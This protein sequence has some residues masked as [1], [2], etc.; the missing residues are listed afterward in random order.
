[1]GTHRPATHS[2]RI[3]RAIASGEAARSALIASWQRSARL[4]GLDP[5]TNAAPQRLTL[6]ELDSLR[7]AMGHMVSAAQASLDRLFQAVGGVGCSVL[8]ADRNGVPVDRRGAASDDATFRDWGLWTGALWNEAAEG[9]NGIGTCLAENRPVIIHRDQHFFA[10]NTALSCMS[11]PIYDEHGELA[12]ALDVS[13][14]RADLTEGFANLISTA[15]MDAA[16]RI[17]AENFRHAFGRARI[18]V[19]EAGERVG[20]SLLAVDRDDLV[21]GATRAARL[22]LGLTDK[23]IAAAVPAPDLLGASGQGERLENGERAIL[24]R[25]LARADGNVSEAA[26]ALGISRAT[27]HRKLNRLGL[28]NA[29]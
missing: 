29:R 8:L 25:A 6:T 13:S 2:E 23:R 10:R 9:T 4:H 19:A 3:T 7:E 20:L 17:E 28:H 27:L 5:A 24:Q 14:C 21:I 26:R 18:V 15:V 1:M 22:A 16:R 12:A 11:A